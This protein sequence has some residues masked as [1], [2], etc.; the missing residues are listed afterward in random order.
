[1]KKEG[2]RQS[3]HFPPW[4]YCQN[5]REIYSLIQQIVTEHLP[6]VSAIQEAGD[7]VVAT[8]EMTTIHHWRDS[9]Q[10]MRT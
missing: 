4:Q 5:Q 6:H 2:S 10:L 1:M 3:K 8:A 7:I 9:P